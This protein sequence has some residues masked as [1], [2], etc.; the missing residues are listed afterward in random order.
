MLRSPGGAAMP[1]ILGWPPDVLTSEQAAFVRFLRVEECWSWR[2]VA[3]VCS[4]AWGGG[5][6]SNQIAGVELCKTAAAVYGE[7][8]ME[9]PWN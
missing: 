3:S 5:W 8:H 1:E 4:D 6:G 2:G 7:S 9:E